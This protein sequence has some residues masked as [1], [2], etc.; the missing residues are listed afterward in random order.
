MDFEEFKDY[1]NYIKETN[2]FKKIAE[3]TRM[4]DANQRLDMFENIK[5]YLGMYHP[6]TDCAEFGQPDC[7]HFMRFFEKYK[8][9]EKAN[10]VLDDNGFI[11]L[12]NTLHITQPRRFFG[13]SGCFLDKQIMLTD[14]TKYIVKL[15]L[16]YKGYSDVR[17]RYCMYNS[18]I[19]SNIAKIL[20]VDTA[21]YRLGRLNNGQH[22]VL[23]KNFLKPNEEFVTFTD[24]ED[25]V[26]GHLN[27]MK[28]ALTLRKYSEKEIAN[29]EFEF[30]KQEFIAKLIGLKDQTPDNSPL[31]QSIDEEGNK[32]IKMAPMM[33]FD[34][35]FHIAT[36]RDDM[37]VRKCENGKADIDSLIREHKDYPG[38]DEFVKSSL[39][40]LNMEQIFRNIYEETGLAKFREYENDAEMM[41]FIKY[42]EYN[43]KKAKETVA[44]V[45][46]NE[47]GERE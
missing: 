18:I 46:K 36:H 6:R 10:I 47:R 30:L 15:P 23:S 25:T 20:E 3:F 5:T 16:D 11:D 17:N 34:Y 27:K 26:S 28:D 21:E 41:N 37:I 31:I 38:F 43:V 29:C 32:H 45:Y 14:G 22:R 8:N 33:D 4:T 19:A 1:I 2:E 40:K 42:V 39:E 7:V 9:N 35:S 44:D 24:N 13:G 12:K